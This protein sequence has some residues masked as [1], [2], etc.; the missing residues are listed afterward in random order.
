MA[1]KLSLPGNL[2]QDDTFSQDLLRQFDKRRSR[3][4]FELG[5]T[6]QEPSPES[7]RMTTPVDYYNEEPI[8]LDDDEIHPV[9]TR[10]T[11]ES[12]SYYSQHS[13]SR[14]SVSAGDLLRKSSAFLKS[15]FDSLKKS[16]HSNRSGV[17]ISSSGSQSNNNN[18]P[19]A[20]T[21]LVMKT[22]I[23]IP[24]TTTRASSLSPRGGG[25]PTTHSPAITQYPPKPLVYSPIEPIPPHTNTTNNNNNSTSKP[26]LHRLSMPLLRVYNETT[27]SR[28]RSITSF[29]RRRKSEPDDHTK[30]KAHAAATTSAKKN[31]Q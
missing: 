1:H 29:G 7:S 21:K 16:G 6:S 22:T 9:P 5:F 27:L 28:H 23:S 19:N 2:T 13:S 24:S 15:K 12:A 30:R 17:D 20:P 10:H 3:L 4:H 31:R 18:H 26:L 8:Q 25:I 14:R 11:Q